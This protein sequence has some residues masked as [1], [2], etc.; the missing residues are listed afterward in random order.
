MAKSERFLRGECIFRGKGEKKLLMF[1]KHT[2]M[3]N[4]IYNIQMY[5]VCSTAYVYANFNVCMYV[6]VCENE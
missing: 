1:R 6:R 2:V 4:T 3:T 5:V